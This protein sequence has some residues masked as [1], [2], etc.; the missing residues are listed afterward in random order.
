VDALGP[1]ERNYGGYIENWWGE[2]YVYYE[3]DWGVYRSDMPGALASAAT[4][5]EIKQFAWPTVE[6]MSYDAIPGL[7]MKYDDHAIMYGFA[8]IFTRPCN[9]RGFEKF[10]TDMYENPEYCDFMIEKMANFYIDDYTK[11]YEVSGNRIDI[12]L[13]MGD[14]STQIAPMISLSM[15]D[16]LIAPHLKRLIE[17]IHELGAYVMYHS[18]G[19]AF[20]FYDRLIDCGVDI[21]DP[22]QRTTANMHPENIAN[23]FGGRTCFHGGIDVQ[24]TLPGGTEEDVRTEVRRYIDAFRDKNGYI[25]ASAHYMQHDTPPENVLALYD[26][27][28]KYR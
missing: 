23:I 22:M 18:C 1:A 28:H 12:F 17:R 24:T 9:M 26:E 5:D 2:R 27:V 25:C 7:C 4:L 13:I 14:L 20:H 15:F 6:M 21:L 10:L 19:E 3:N 11:A 16:E 8:D